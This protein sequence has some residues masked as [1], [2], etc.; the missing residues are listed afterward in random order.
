MAE[1]HKRT[2]II[3]TIIISLLLSVLLMKFPSHSSAASISL[4]GS[5]IL[6]YMG[7]V[8]LL[9]M[10][11]LGTKSVMGLVFRDLAPVLKIHKWIGKYGTLAIFLHPVL[12][13]FSYG[14]HWLYSFTPQLGTVAERHTLLGQIALWVLLGVWVTSALVCDKLS[15]RTWRYLHWLAYICVPFALLHVPDLGSQETSSV[16]VKAYLVVL[17][18]TFAGFSLLRLRSFLNLDRKAYRVVRHV[19]LTD[20]DYMIQLAPPSDIPIAP[21][22]GQYVYA[23][24][25]YL[26]EDHPFSVTQYNETSG[27][28]TLTYRI[29][30]MYT[31]ELAKV[32]AG[33]SIYLSGAYGS[34]TSEL[35]ETDSSPVVYISGG[36]GI[37][38][39]VDR[40]MRE[41]DT[42]EQWLFA[43]NRT[44][45]LAVLYEPLKKR[46]GDHAVAIYSRDSSELQSNE[47]TGYV[48]FDVLQK[49]LKQPTDYRYYICGPPTMITSMTAMLSNNGISPS[50]IHSEEFAW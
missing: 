50:A 6:G 18:V 5:A 28:I 49:Y 10:Y 3:F 26:S 46:L 42:R 39:F 17:A 44:K 24:L 13:T 48:T 22:R 7:I 37:T 38:P 34:F 1:A 12:I 9:W 45:P 23:K 11:I 14:E 20:E 30:G 16:L 40:I 21:R 19:Q 8:L 33:R 41:S 27:E 47:E 4:W 29:A 15:F 36:I 2:V 32:S 31:K 25:G 43:A 35:A